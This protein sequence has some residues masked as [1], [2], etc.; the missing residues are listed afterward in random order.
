MHMMYTFSDASFDFTYWK[1]HLFDTQTK[2][3]NLNHIAT[4]A[5]ATKYVIPSLPG[6]LVLGGERALGF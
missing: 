3:L 1:N 5:A 2:L 6:R 4:C